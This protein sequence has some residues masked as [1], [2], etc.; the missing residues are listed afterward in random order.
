[1]MKILDFGIA[2]MKNRESPDTVVGELKGKPSYMAPEHLRALGVDRRADIYSASV[3]LHELLTGRK[4]FTRESVFATIHAVETLA[5]PTPSSINPAIPP[6]LDEIVLKGLEKKADN[7]FQDAKTMAG[8]LERM[9]AELEGPTLERF[10]EGEL[11][12]EREA[13]RAWLLGV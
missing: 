10:V 13:H 9:I 5:V 11:G 7:R 3:V 8:E 1:R 6:G 12:A 2:F 4:L